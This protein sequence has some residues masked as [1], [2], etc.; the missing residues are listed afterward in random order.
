MKILAIL[1]CWTLFATAL[2]ASSPKEAVE[3][4]LIECGSAILKKD[5]ESAAV[6]AERLSKMASMAH[7]TNE[8]SDELVKLYSSQDAEACQSFARQAKLE[9]S[10]ELG[11]YLSGSV[12]Q[13]AE[14]KKLEEKAAQKERAKQQEAK[15]KQELLEL[16]IN[17]KVFASC[18]KLYFMD[19]V[20][21]FTNE[22]CVNSFKANGFPAN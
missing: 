11:R 12:R 2:S 13:Q 4:N 18:T 15:A 7:A 5:R 21:A 22:L 14:R 19:E 9:F 3:E 20:A 10:P 16:T 6:V 8:L 1:L 17:S